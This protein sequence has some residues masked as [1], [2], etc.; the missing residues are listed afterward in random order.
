[1]VTKGRGRPEEAEQH[2]RHALALYAEIYEPHHPK[3]A[4]VELNLGK[5]LQ[6]LGREAEA[7]EQLERA[8]AAFERY[9]GPDHP[10][11][12][13]ALDALGLLEHQR[14]H[15]EEA[16]VHQQRALE[17]FE[18][19]YPSE[20]SHP[21]IARALWA[22]G[23]T[24]LELGRLADARVLLERALEIQAGA[25]VRAV[26][27]AQTELTLATLRW[28]AGERDDARAL[29]RQSSARVEHEHGEAAE[30]LRR[31]LQAWLAAHR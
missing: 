26:D 14:G 1:V 31:E 11:V 28:R 29:A 21:R 20:P 16:R 15:L 4:M 27:R 7:A 6:S 30:R 12:G 22:L 9:G 24:E 18:R 8:R 5:V 23:R 10:D 19:A 3:A 17:I 2:Y 13:K 25:D